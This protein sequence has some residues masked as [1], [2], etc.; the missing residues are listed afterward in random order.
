ME[1]RAPRLGPCAIRSPSLL[2]LLLL[3]APVSASGILAVPIALS[4]PFSF[5]TDYMLILNASCVFAV[6]RA[7]AGVFGSLMCFY[8]HL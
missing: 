4:G 7:L 1:F 3:L 2:L 8:W 6:L 5:A